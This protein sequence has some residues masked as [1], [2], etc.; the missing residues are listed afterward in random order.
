MDLA[1]LRQEI[2]EIDRQI[3]DLFEKRIQVS[4]NVARYKIETGK[5]V[6]DPVRENAKIEAAKDMASTAFNQKGLEAL[7]KQM[8]TISRIRQYELIAE[9]A[10]E[11]FPFSCVPQLDFEGCHIVFQGVAGAYGHQATLGYFGEEADIDHVV[12]FEEVMQAVSCGRADFGVLPVENSSTGIITDVYDLMSRYD[13][14]IVGEYEVRVDHALLG[15]KGAGINGIR[16]VYSHPQGLMQCSRF[17][18]THP[19]WEQISLLNTAVS[20]RKVQEEGRP[21][22][23]AIASTLAADYYGLDVLKSGIS[24]NDSNATRFI[25]IHNHK[26]YEE[27]AD[28]ISIT[29]ELAHETGSLFHV[30]GFII[31]NNLNMTKIE[32]RPIQ[33]EKWRYRFFIDIDG[34]LSDM[35][36]RSA[37]REVEK[38]TS[39]FHILG[40][41]R[42]K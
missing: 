1:K 30:L 11:A 7:F 2:D 9:K 14:C 28:R 13:I 41:Y 35:A 22:Q 33:G 42:V 16:T 31:Y 17:L 40:N 4:E 36:V 25:I 8:M 10:P 19:D 26:V 39:A 5:A 18:R 37:L 6:Y 32:S 34:S 20:A 23:A 38:E 15:L 21:D 3:I 29:F 24:D 12:S 27:S